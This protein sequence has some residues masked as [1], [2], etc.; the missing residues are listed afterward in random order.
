MNSSVLGKL[1]LEHE[2]FSSIFISPKTYAFWTKANKFITKAKG[3]NSESLSY[4]DYLDLLYGKNIKSAIRTQSV[5][6]WRKGV[7]SI[8]DIQLIM[9]TDSYKKR[10]KTI[11]TELGNLWVDTRPIIINELDKS[12]VLY[13]NKFLVVYKLWNCVSKSYL[14]N[15]YKSDPIIESRLFSI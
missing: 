10:T 13:K 8:E 7:V 6:D 9:S 5:K 3:V 11:I 12:L 2:L 14:A 4:L 1:K 15:I